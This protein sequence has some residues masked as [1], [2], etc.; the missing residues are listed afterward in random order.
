MLDAA[1]MLKNGPPLKRSVVFVALTAE[2]KGLLG[3][4][5]FAMNPSVSEQSCQRQSRHADP[6]A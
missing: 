1:R 6:D 5:C 4:Q 3:A 2:E